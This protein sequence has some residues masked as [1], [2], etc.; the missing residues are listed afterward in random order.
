M[1]MDMD[2][3][4]MINHLSG[5]ISVLVIVCDNVLIRYDNSFILYKSVV[6]PRASFETWYSPKHC[7][8]S[9]YES[10]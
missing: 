5:N 10:V 6:Q 4:G 9:M 7:N 3:G 2:G 8:T 1:D